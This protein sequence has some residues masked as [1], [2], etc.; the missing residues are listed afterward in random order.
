MEVYGVK[1]KRFTKEWWGYFW[2]YYKWHTIS[3][4]GIALV[5]GYSCV[6]C[7]TATK[8]DLQVDYVSEHGIL[9]QQ[10][11]ALAELIKANIDEIHNNDSIDAFVLALNGTPTRDPQAD[12]AIQAKIMLE[13]SFSESFAFIMSKQYVD[14][15]SQ[16]EMFEKNALWAG[17]K[18]A[19]GYAVSLEN[20]TQLKEI[21]I[22][23]DDC[24]IAVR[25][26]RKDEADDEIKIAEQAN[27]IKLA[28]YLI[29]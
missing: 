9:E 29:Q 22:N 19:E 1:P 14:Y 16:A 10:Q 3:V 4:L 12:Q 28:Q 27:A 24:Y 13:Q 15:Y 8:Y 21:G 26:L 6:Q 25:K 2:D 7:A 18:A 17:D 5:V 23:T 11:T 20:C